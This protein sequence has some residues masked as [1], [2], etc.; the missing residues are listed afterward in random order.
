MMPGITTDNFAAIRAAQNRLIRRRES[1]IENVMERYDVFAAH[2]LAK[3]K[4]FG[5]E[6]V[7]E[8]RQEYRQ[9]LEEHAANT[10]DAV[11]AIMDSWS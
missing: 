2:L 5:A 3:T 6:H 4:E 9:I 7:A 8:R 10:V 11:L 1:A